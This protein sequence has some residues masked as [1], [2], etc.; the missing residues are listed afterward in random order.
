[1]NEN[2]FEHAVEEAVKASNRY[3]LF[4]IGDKTPVVAMISGGSDS[5]ALAY[6]LSVLSSRDVIGPVQAVHINH[7]LRDEDSDN[8]ERFVKTLCEA[9]DIP[10]H[11]FR[12][13]IPALMKNGGNMEAIARNSRYNA[14]NEIL[15]KM[16]DELGV[17]KELGRIVVAHTVDDRLECF[18]MRSIVGTGPGGFRGMRDANGRVVRPLLE[19]DR[20]ELREAIKDAQSQLP[21]VKD[22]EGHLWREDKTNADIDHFRAYVRHE[23]VPRAK[24]WNASLGSTMTRTMNLI[25]AED[26]MLEEMADEIVANNCCFE[27]YADGKIKA[28][29]EYDANGNITG[30]II[31]KY[32]A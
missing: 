21:V 10:L 27:Y 9:L 32:E 22:R 2:G 30:K 6:I 26:D 29:S 14:A 8:D 31:Y 12:I 28:E 16:C 11:S 7:C 20:Y 1:M 4:P 18:Y 17:D 25:G 15:D 3:G 13:D 5:T 24:K 23:I 19:L